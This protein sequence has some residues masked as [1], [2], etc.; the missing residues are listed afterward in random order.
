MILT[1]TCSPDQEIPSC[2][3]ETKSDKLWIKYFK[4]PNESILGMMLSSIRLKKTYAIDQI[5]WY[6]TINLL[7]FEVYGA[8]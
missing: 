3:F 5:T 8:L 2:S 7:E 1:G 4:S 6:D